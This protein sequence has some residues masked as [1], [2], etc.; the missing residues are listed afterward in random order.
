MF[1]C[2][3]YHDWMKSPELQHLTA[4]EP[5]SLEEEYRMQQSWSEDEDK[6]TFIILDRPIYEVSKDEI[7]AM[8][9]DTNL[10]FHSNEDHVRVAEAEIMIAEVASRGKRRGWEALLLMLRYGDK[11]IL[12]QAPLDSL[13]LGCEK[14]HVGK[15][16]AKISTDNIQSIA[17]FSKLGFQEVEH[18]IVFNE[19]TLQREVDHCWRQWLCTETSSSVTLT[20][21]S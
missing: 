18:N 11:L 1:V 5:L 6:C 12:I 16:E 10:F 20:T 3:R 19:L 14:L 8:I 21:D 9:G 7:A 4:S 17:M 15:F 2:C 13:D